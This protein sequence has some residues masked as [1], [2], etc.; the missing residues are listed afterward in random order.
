MDPFKNDWMIQPSDWRIDLTDA[1]DLV[2]DFNENENVNDETLMLSDKNDND[3]TMSQN[4]IKKLNDYFDKMI[5]RS[6]W[7]ED[8]T[9]SLKK[10]ENLNQYCSINDFNDKELKSKIFK[11]KLVDMSNDIDEKLFEKIFGDT[12]EILAN[13]LI[14]MINKEQNQIILKNISANKKKLHEQEKTAPYDW[15]IQPSYRRNN[16]IKAIKLI[17]DFNESELKDLVWKYK[18]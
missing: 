12:L 17:L 14:N 4:K 9:E 15:V 5:D 3:E 11:L 16:L 13:K 18:N 7:F 6:K 8:Q 2:L 1:I 10:V